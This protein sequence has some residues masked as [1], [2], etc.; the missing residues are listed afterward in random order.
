[1]AQ[2][3]ALPLLLPIP[4]PIKP[5]FLNQNHHNPQSTTPLSPPQQTTS[6]SPSFTPLLQ[7]FLHQQNPSHTSSQHF[8]SPSFIPRN[9]TR[10]GKSRDVNHGKPWSNH[11]LSDAGQRVLQCLID[12]SFDVKD[13]DS[14]LLQLF[15]SYRENP[16]VMIDGLSF[17]MLGIV[18]GLGF[19]KKCDLALSVF[20]WLRSRKDCELVL[21]GSVIPV[22]ISM[23]GKEGK[24]DS[25]GGG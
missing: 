4:P 5:L 6:P 14:V 11:H 18:K 23:L 12:E 7:D 17:D 20:E 19:Y 21:N 1:M 16:D 15:E 8:N 3:L 24:S 25:D 2:H 9:R 10:I 13:I 22:I